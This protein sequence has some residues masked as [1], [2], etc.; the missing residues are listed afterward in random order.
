MEAG[1]RSLSEHP[2]IAYRQAKVT[3]SLMDG[4]IHLKAECWPSGSTRLVF[5]PENTDTLFP[6]DV[7]LPILIIRQTP[8][9]YQAQDGVLDAWLG[10][11]TLGRVGM[12][13]TG[14]CSHCISPHYHTKVWWWRCG[15]TEAHT[16]PTR[17]D[18]MNFHSKRCVWP[19]L[20]VE[21]HF[22]CLLFLTLKISLLIS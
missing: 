15:T 18:D 16:Q 10:K 11:G 20:K 6:V 17:P 22:C 12:L 13:T 2:H 19:N 9:T 3:H 21:M 7:Q 1:A 14:E 5:V 4:H 8:P